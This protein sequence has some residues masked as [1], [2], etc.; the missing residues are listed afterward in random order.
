MADYYIYAVTYKEENYTRYINKVKYTMTLAYDGGDDEKTR[1][2][3]V[4]DIDTMDRKVMTKR[5]VNGVWKEGES[6][7]V[8]EQ[9]DGDKFIR[10]DWNKTKADNLENLPEY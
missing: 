1:H 3:V 10:T 5:K 2:D 7:H 9:S 8:I 6:V 4:F